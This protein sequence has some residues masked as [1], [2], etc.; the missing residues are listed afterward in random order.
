M[1]NLKGHAALVTGGSKGIGKG[2]ALAL[3]TAGA[4]VVISARNAGDARDTLKQVRAKGVRAGFVRADLSR[5]EDN[6][7]V[8]AGALRLFP[9]LDILVCNAGTAG[10]RPLLENSPETWDRTMNLNLRGTYFTAQAFAKRLVAARRP[11]RIILVGSTNSFLAE[12]NSSIYDTSKGGVAMMVKTFAV[13]LAKHRIHVNGIAP[14]LVET[15]LVSWV[16][17]PTHAKMRR[18]YERNIPLGRIGRIEDCGGAVAFLASSLAD[19]ITGQFIVID[20]GLISQQVAP[21]D[22][23]GEQP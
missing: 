8:V 10:E 6:R 17:D 7:R 19:Y 3:A 14:G 9:R 22:H 1:I 12:D 21:H 4:D 2:I 23:S 16:T 5:L 20:G 11:G 15:P 18:D 13:S